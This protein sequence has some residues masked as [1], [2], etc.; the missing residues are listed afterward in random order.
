MSAFA[1]EQAELAANA[2]DALDHQQRGGA[3]TSE[4]GVK[5]GHVVEDDD[6]S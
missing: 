5:D 6:Q 2:L 3:T 4:S 1:R